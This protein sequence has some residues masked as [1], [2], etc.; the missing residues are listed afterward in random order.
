MSGGSGEDRS[1]AISCE[2]QL[3]SHNAG[4]GL[5]SEGEQ[6]YAAFNFDKKK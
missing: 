2:R 5:R 4:R 6:R 1:P 3:S